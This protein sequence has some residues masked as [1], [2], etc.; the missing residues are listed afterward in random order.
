MESFQLA[1][2]SGTVRKMICRASAQDLIGIR[3]TEL[4]ELKDFDSWLEAD[5]I[6]Y[7]ENVEKKK[8]KKEDPIIL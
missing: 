1:F 8:K 7:R 2:F 6:P 5:K 3:L 4:K